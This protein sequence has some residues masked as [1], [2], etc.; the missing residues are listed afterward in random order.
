[1]KKENAIAL[2]SRVHEESGRFIT[3]ELAAH[4]ITGI[5]PSHGDIFNVL[6]KKEKCT[7]K[8]IA[9]SIHRTKPTVTVL[10]DKLVDEGYVI[11]E[12][13]SSDSRVTYVTLTEKGISLK[14]AIIDIS[15]RLN[16]L[17][18]G[19]LT[20][21]E[22]AILERVLQKIETRFSDQADL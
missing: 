18:Y 8:E 17:V 10:V 6:F 5:V 3:K 22:S 14:P 12:K 9:E 19:N 2:V 7:M 11:K 4:G 13:S 20:D 1:M 21:A 15:E 16:E